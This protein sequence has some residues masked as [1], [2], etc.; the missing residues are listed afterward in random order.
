MPAANHLS[1]GK[2]LEEECQ[3]LRDLVE[4]H[5]RSQAQNRQTIETLEHELAQIKS[6]RDSY[7]RALYAWSRSQVPEEELKRWATEQDTG[8]SFDQVL[9]GL[10]SS[11]TH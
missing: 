1:T 4:D 3:R 7:V 9:A 8:E 10:T 11:K 6:E 2:S 5:E